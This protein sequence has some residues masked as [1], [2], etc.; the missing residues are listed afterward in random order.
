MTEFVNKDLWTK[1][2]DERFRQAKKTD[3]ELLVSACPFCHRSLT[4]AAQRSSSNIQILDI[5]ELVA[6][7]LKD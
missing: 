7:Q 3:P 2:G 5:A 6:K 1:M 4:Q